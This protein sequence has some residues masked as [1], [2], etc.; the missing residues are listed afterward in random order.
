MNKNLIYL[1]LSVSFLLIGTALNAQDCDFYFPHEKG[2]TIE[3]TNYDKKGDE[4]GKSTAT[5][6]ENTTIGNA[7][8][9][10]VASEY[11]DVKGDS[12]L[13]HEFTVKCENGEFYINMDSYLNQ[14]SMSAYQNMEVDIDVEQMTLPSNLKAGQILGNGRVTA[15]VSNS[16]INIMTMNVD[17]TNRKVDGFE[18]VTTPAGTFDCVKISYDMEMKMMFKIKMSGVQWFAKNV[19]A[20]KTESY[21]K[22]GKLEGSSLITKIIK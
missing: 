21:N 9:V 10:K 2:T 8:V 18:K 19:G 13:K 5:I 22:K 1:F 3:T 11:K 4:T 15:K 17:I 20:V 6:L 7:T 16:G 12:T 14:Q